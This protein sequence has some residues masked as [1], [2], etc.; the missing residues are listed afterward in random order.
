MGAWLRSVS[1][2]RSRRFRLE[3]NVARKQKKLAQSWRSNKANIVAFFAPSMAF[4]LYSTVAAAAGTNVTPDGRTQTQLTTVGNITD[5]TTSTVSNGNAF[6]SF[7]QFQVG[8]GDTVNL[9]V[10]DSAQRLLNVVHDGP[11]NVDGIVNGYKN[12]KIGGDVYFADPYGFVVGKTGSV[13][14]GSLTVRT[15]T[16]DATEKLIDQN[17]HI[18]GAT[19]SG[20]IDG[21]L[22]V[23]PDGSV[24]IRGKIHTVNGAHISAQS[25]DTTAG[26]GD[27]T[28]FDGSVNTTGLQQGG[29][30][31]ATNGDIEITAAGNATIGGTVAANGASGQSAGHIAITAVNDISLDKT[32]SISAEGV[33]IASNGGN[34]RCTL[35]AISTSLRARRPMSAPG[36]PVMAAPSN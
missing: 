17:G 11:V 29:D 3:A 12:G 36:K 19:A 35:A 25:V 6:N 13:N 21:T 15:P 22:P 24:V 2:A 9:H 23:S 14:V 18:D 27:T 5:V 8:Q 1:I 10:P 16:K 20:V 31:R 33:G 32:S 34:I 7:S 4:A 30:I 28:D 26:S